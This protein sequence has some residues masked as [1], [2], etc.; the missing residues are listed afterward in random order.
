MPLHKACFYSEVPLFSALLSA[1]CIYQDLSHMTPAVKLRKGLIQLWHSAQV[2]LA[3]WSGSEQSNYIFTYCYS[4]GWK[5]P[6]NCG[7]PAVASER[8]RKHWSKRDPVKQI[9][10]LIV[11]QAYISPHL[12]KNLLVVKILVYDPHHPKLKS[13]IFFLLN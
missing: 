5:F 1:V 2:S 12:L 7:Y 9:E 6:R 8:K 10:V 13:L 11:I 3:L 4:P